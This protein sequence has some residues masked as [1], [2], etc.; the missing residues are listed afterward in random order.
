MDARIGLELFRT[1][2][3]ASLGRVLLREDGTDQKLGHD[4]KEQDRKTF[5]GADPAWS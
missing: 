5:H 2:Q 3:E 4:R 1:L